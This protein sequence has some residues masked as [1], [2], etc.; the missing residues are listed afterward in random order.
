MLK[1]VKQ[2]AAS[3]EGIDIYPVISLLIFFLFFVGMLYLVKRMDQKSVEE[4]SS[5]PLDEAGDLYTIF[6]SQANNLHQS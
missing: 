2:H 5:L 4:I 3:I 6:P 1:F